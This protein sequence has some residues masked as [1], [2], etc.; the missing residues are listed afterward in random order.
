MRLQHFLVNA[1]ARI[2]NWQNGGTPW[3]VGVVAP[4]EEEKDHIP[5]GGHIP[6]VMAQPAS[7]LVTDERVDFLVIPRPQHD[8]VKALQRGQREKWILQP[9]R[10]VDATEVKPE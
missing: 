2:I 5:V 1:L 6:H 7:N 8:L 4:I 9:P 3:I 10:P